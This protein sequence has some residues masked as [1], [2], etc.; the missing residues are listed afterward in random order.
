MFARNQG[1]IAVNLAAANAWIAEHAGL[2]SWVPPRAGLLSLL[3]YDLDIPSLDLANKLADEY[4]VM[5]AP[6]S[7]FGYENYLRLGI[8][9]DPPVFAAGLQA[10]S[11]CFADLQAGALPVGGPGKEVGP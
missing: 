3:H 1:I 6:G 11:A 2:L 4:G 5:L 9:Q 8:G 7:A 10:A